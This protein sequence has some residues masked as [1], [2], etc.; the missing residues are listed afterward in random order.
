MD[1]FKLGLV[2]WLVHVRTGGERLGTR[3]IL[4]E[5]SGVFAVFT[6]P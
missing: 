5:S 4:R 1:I 2:G 3:P 6:N